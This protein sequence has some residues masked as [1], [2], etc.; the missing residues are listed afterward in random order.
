M[1]LLII[2]IVIAS[3]TATA[4]TVY[5]LNTTTT[6]QINYNYS[7]ATALTPI[8]GLNESIIIDAINA[9]IRAVYKDYEKATTTITMIEHKKIK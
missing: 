2:V 3:A 8:K 5:A 9:K 1:T 6:Q 4:T 7:N